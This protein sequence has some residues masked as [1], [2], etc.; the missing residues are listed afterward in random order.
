[1][2]AGGDRTPPS[3]NGAGAGPH[4]DATPLPQACLYVLK[5]PG[6][7]AVVDRPARHDGDV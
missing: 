3:G 4:L 1:M 5:S 6:S 7:P 2:P